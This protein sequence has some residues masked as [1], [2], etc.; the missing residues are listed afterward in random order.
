V[1]IVLSVLLHGLVLWLPE[2]H[3][4][5]HEMELPPLIA[6]LE[7]LPK[8]SAKIAPKAKPK[9]KA[10]P[11][12]QPEPAVQAAPELPIV[13]S[14]P[15]P[16]SAPAAD[17]TELA[18]AA[19]APIAAEPEPEAA[20]PE[21]QRPPLPKHARLKFNVYQGQGGIKLGESVNTLEIND[22]RYILKAEV[23]TTG[24]VGV[25]KTY[26]LT[27][28]STGTATERTLQPEVFSEEVNNS[29]DKKINRAEFDWA[30][31][32]IHF[33]NGGEAK[34]PARAQDILSI[35]Y[36]FPP[37]NLRVEVITINIA[38]GKQFEEYRF[39]VAYEEQLETAMGT[40]QTVHF[41]KLRG[42]HEEGLEIWFAQEYRFLP[43]KVRHL[44]RDGK[45]SGE[46]IIADIRVSDE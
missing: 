25:F 23:Q 21:P 34:L 14:A 38:T 33:S 36:Q 28:T 40:L 13:A 27:Q 17:E 19:S 32:A 2:I 15:V 44:D 24:L 46:A 12:P 30:N 39:E 10:P 7:P 29:G 4:P 1:A 41:R 22:G 3:L 18:Q 43:V 26:H 8:M 5:K 20:P 37:L 11:K 42:T 35:L 45:I 31:H 16:A 9:A 6:R